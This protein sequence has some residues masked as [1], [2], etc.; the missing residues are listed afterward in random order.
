MKE[1]L[2]DSGTYLSDHRYRLMIY[3]AH[4]TMV[5]YSKTIITREDMTIDEFMQVN[6]DV[7]KRVVDEGLSIMDYELS[8]HQ[9]VK[10]SFAYLIGIYSPKSVYE[11]DVYIPEN[12]RQ[13]SSQNE[14]SLTKRQK[15]ILIKLYN[16]YETMSS[17]NLG[18]TL[19]F[20]GNDSTIIHS[21]STNQLLLK[22]LIDSVSVGIHTDGYKL[23]K[24]GKDLVEHFLLKTVS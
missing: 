5:F 17:N 14:I 21:K 11:E 1:F 13:K 7:I 23:T 22:N 9:L 3:F 20:K 8:H 19:L 6:R 2:I 18:S 15:E 10:A 4:S 24:T 12:K 16:G